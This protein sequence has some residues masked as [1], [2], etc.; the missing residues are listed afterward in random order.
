MRCCLVRYGFGHV[1]LPNGV[2]AGDGWIVD[3]AGELP[4]VFSQFAELG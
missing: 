1:T 3:H 2:Q 4:D